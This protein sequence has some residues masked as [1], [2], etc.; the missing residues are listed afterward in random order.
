MV[1]GEQPLFGQRRNKLDRKKRVAH[2][3][4]VHQKPKLRR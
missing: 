3:L 4:F 2:R 1:K